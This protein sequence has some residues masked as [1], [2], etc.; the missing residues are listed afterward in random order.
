MKG[1]R[2]IYD[3]VNFVNEEHHSPELRYNLYNYNLSQ[4]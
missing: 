2:S 3:K 1:E 4:Q